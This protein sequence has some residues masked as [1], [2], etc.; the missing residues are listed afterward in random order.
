MVVMKESEYQI[1]V[2]IPVYNVE[3]FVAECLDSLLNQELKQDLKIQVILLDDA[4]TDNSTQIAMNY[5][6]RYQ[7]VQYKRHK[8]NLGLS[9]AR[10]TGLKYCLGEYVFFLDGDDYVSVSCLDQL[11]AKAIETKAELVVG[12]FAQVANE[13][14]KYVRK[15]DDDLDHSE[16]F[17]RV[18]SSRLPNVAWGQLIKKSILDNAGFKWVPGVLHE[19][20]YTSLEL[21]NLASKIEFVNGHLVFWRIREHSIGQTISKRTIHDYLGAFKHRQ[22]YMYR[23]NLLPEKIELFE[24]G[25]NKCLAN[26]LTRISQAKGKKVQ[27]TMYLFFLI[28]KLFNFRSLM[29]IPVSRFRLYFTNTA[30]N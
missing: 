29:L 30:K 23:M 13:K 22:K 16:Y 26:I 17:D 24:E 25:L 14:I 9:E 15:F 2:V 19:D 4:S 3:D 21:I 1:S 8:Q 18:L 7:H 11:Y 28:I 6:E 12:G 20:V 10:N 27:L 5:A